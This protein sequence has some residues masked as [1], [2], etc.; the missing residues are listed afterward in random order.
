MVVIMLK[1]NLKYDQQTENGKHFFTIKSELYEEKQFMLQDLQAILQPIVINEMWKISEL[2][3]QIEAEAY[4]NPL[5]HIIGIEEMRSG[6]KWIQYRLKLYE[7]HFAYSS[8]CKE[9]I[10]ALKSMEFS[11]QIAIKDMEKKEQTK[12][13]CK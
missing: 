2:K 13:H 4:K 9:H 10:T 8:A 5:Q 7:D 12:E 6:L 3:H 1:T 11:L